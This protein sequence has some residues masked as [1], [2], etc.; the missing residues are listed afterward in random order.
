MSPTLKAAV[1]E[2]L[3]T[4]TLVFV[5][6]FVAAIAGGGQGV[7]AAALG[8]GLVLVGIIYAFGSISGAH[9]NP[10]I[11]ISLLVGNKIKIDRALIYI[12]AQLIGAVL[13]AVLASLTGAVI[14]NAAGESVAINA[15]GQTI[16]SLT[17]DAVWAAALFE[18]ILTFFLATT[19]W[20]AAVYGHG[21]GLQGVAIGFTLAASI[22]AGGLFTGASLN[23]ARTLGPALLAGDFSYVIPYFVGIF[24]GGIIAGVVHGYVLT[25]EEPAVE[26]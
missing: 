23:P 22:L 2:L 19:V 25:P 11:T 4:F 14:T 15:A 13:A 18:A 26:P 17:A 16:G 8:H 12:V 24:A 20:Q 21:R 9:V 5:G 10:A 6:I 3:G 1:A 7:V